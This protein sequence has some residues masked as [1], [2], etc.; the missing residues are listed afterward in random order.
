MQSLCSQILAR[1]AAMRV[2]LTREVGRC[3]AATLE[4]SD[5]YLSD[6]HLHRCV[7]RSKHDQ[8][9]WRSDD[10]R[11]SYDAERHDHADADGNRELGSSAHDDGMA[12][13]TIFD[14]MIY[15]EVFK[16]SGAKD[17]E[18]DSRL[19][20]SL[21]SQKMSTSTLQDKFVLILVILKNE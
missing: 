17:G 11:C 1:A 7:T 8:V 6:E 5:R 4:E 9:G 2:E 18:L 14:S 13:W 19:R 16:T 20:L 10:A 15:R 21:V 12:L 3:L